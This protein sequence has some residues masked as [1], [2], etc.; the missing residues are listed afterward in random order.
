MSIGG[1]YELDSI[2]IA[3]LVDEARSWR[4]DPKRAGR[5]VTETAAAALDAARQLDPDSPVAAY[6]AERAER[7]LASADEG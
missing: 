7:L 6:V 5:V 4:H 3:D 1:R 2:T